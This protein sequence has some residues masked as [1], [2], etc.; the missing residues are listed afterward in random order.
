[1]NLEFFAIDMQVLI[2]SV[3]YDLIAFLVDCF[4]SFV[5]INYIVRV[6]CNTGSGRIKEQ[7]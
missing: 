6:D 3:L 1:M 2:I 7:L 4:L 5:I